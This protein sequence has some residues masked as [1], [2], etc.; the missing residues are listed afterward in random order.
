MTTEQEKLLREIRDFLKPKAESFFIY[1]NQSETV[2]VENLLKRNQ[3]FSDDY[4]KSETVMTGLWEYIILSNNK[5]IWENIKVDI[6]QSQIKAYATE[7]RL[8]ITGSVGT[9]EANVGDLNILDPVKGTQTNDMKI[10]LDGENVNIGDIS[11]GVQ[12]NDV[13]ITL[14]GENI[15]VD[16]VTE[17][18]TAT[19]TNIA[20]STTDAAP[21][22][23]K[24]G[25]NNDVT[26]IDISKAI[27]I[28]YLFKNSGPSTDADLNIKVSNDNTTY[29]VAISTAAGNGETRAINLANGF[30]YTKPTADNNDASNTLSAEAKILVVRRV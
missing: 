23:F 28:S 30:Y 13:K 5:D 25:S 26:E 11:A 22:T 29:A 4:K 3:I 1:A 24:D 27:S 2:S 16:V 8:P 14:D 17:V 7:T 19:W 9:I 15:K 21:T 20:T 18:Y 10:T 6:M 12:T